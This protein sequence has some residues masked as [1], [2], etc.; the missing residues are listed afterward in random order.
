MRRPKRAGT[1][2]HNQLA[3]TDLLPDHCFWEPNQRRH[4]G[5]DGTPCPTGSDPCGFYALDSLAT[6]DDSVS[7]ALGIPLAEDI[8]P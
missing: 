6:L 3:D 1:V 5:L 4:V 8:T 2:A 7:R